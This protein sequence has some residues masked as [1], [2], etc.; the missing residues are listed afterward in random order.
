MVSLTEEQLA[1]AKQELK[2]RKDAQDKAYHDE[3]VRKQREADERFEA[4][5][6]A[7]Y[8]GVDADTRYAI[9]SDYRNYYD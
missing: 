3:W 1:E 6:N 5:M 4:K 8:P 2:R 7:A 9:Y